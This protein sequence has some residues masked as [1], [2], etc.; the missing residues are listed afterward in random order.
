MEGIHIMKLK[1]PFNLVQGTQPLLLSPM[2]S[3]D[4]KNILEY[5]VMHDDI[6]LIFNTVCELLEIPEWLP[7]E[8][9]IACIYKI[10]EISFGGDLTLR[11]KCP[12]CGRLTESITM[13]DNLLEWNSTQQL[14]KE[15]SELKL[16]KNNLEEIF[17]F[18]ISNAFEYFE[19]VP[20]PRTI[21]DA[22]KYA[23]A[24]RSKIP[25]IKRTV[26][27]KCFFCLSIRKINITNKKFII[28]S[29]SEQ[30]ALTMIKQYNALAMNGFTKHDTDSMLPF[31]RE[32]HAKLF[33]D[34]TESMKQ[35]KEKYHVNM[36]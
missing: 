24:L 29:L 18:N 33:K 26:D 19:G 13:L 8:L 6:N 35:T 1:V 36:E 7:Y 32:V 25:S 21:T 10:R 2:Y 12:K 31:E 16:K 9:K 3:K 17:K 15:L 11:Y 4:E 5:G 23:I 14:P 28:D 30:T 27:C 34:R 22:S 20:T